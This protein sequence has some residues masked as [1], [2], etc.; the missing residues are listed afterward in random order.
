MPIRTPPAWGLE[1]VSETL[2]T[3]TASPSDYWPH[4][5]KT[6]RVSV[7]RIGWADVR[8]ALREGFS[9]FGALRTDV[10][11]LCIFY[12]IVGLLLA[13]AAIGNDFLPLLFPLASGFALIGPF[14][15]V[16][17]N[18]MSRRR[19]LGIG[20]VGWTSA[21]AVFR[22]PAFGR[23]LMLGA[24]MVGLFLAWIVIAHAI[25]NHTLGP[26]QPTSIQQFMND[27]LY[28]R[29]GWAMTLIGCVVGLV[30]AIIAFAVSVVSFP[31][32]LDRDVSL[33][34]AVSTS[35][36]AVVVNPVVMA[37]WGLVIAASLVVASIPVLLGLVIVLPVLGHATWH[38]YRRIVQA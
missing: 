27:V 3:R 17:L 23:I 32:L 37:L 9:D 30:F 4:A 2:Q 28:T 10:A 24:G 11:F 12:P 26:A 36:R 19:E 13:R 33:D 16:G 29:A 15:A 34:T 18:E 21:F 35:L 6:S 20:N 38:L 22:S 8:D 5:G 1:K 7:R 25:Y 14:A 31:M